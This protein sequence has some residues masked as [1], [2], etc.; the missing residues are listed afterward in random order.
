MMAPTLSHMQPVPA[1]TFFRPGRAYNGPSPA[2]ALFEVY[3][4][5]L[6]QLLLVFVSTCSLPPQPGRVHNR[7]IY[8]GDLVLAPSHIQPVLVFT[9]S[10]PLQTGRVHDRASPY[11]ALNE[12]YLDDPDPIYLAASARF[13]IFSASSNIIINF[14]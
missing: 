3:L 14:T 12:V 5:D 2:S 10:L 13:N 11:S 4:G 1:S 8:L 9:C 7:V 6:T